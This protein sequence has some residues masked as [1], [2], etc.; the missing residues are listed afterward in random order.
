M[1]AARGVMNPVDVPLTGVCVP[2]CPARG[3][4]VC[5]YD[6]WPKPTFDELRCAGAAAACHAPG[7][8]HPTLLISNPSRV[9]V[10]LQVRQPSDC[11]HLH[12]VLQVLDG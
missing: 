4:V 5:L 12:R 1:A 3:S 9:C 10:Q 11:Q 8:A 6:Y 2:S 7:R